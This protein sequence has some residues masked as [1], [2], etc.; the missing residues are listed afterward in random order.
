MTAP[1]VP[2]P[3]AKAAFLDRGD[4]VRDQMI[5]E[6]VALVGGAPKL[7][8]GGVDGLADAVPDPGCVDLDELAFESVL[9][10]VSPVE[11][12]GMR[13][14]IIDIGAGAYGD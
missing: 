4:I 14:R 10:D 1:L 13:V 12:F 5:P 11:L 7:S 3:A 8:G 2:G 6:V 9:E